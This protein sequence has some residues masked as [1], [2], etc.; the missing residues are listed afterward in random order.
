LDTDGL[1]NGV[2]D[3]IGAAAEWLTPDGSHQ[4]FYSYRQLTQGAPS[5]GQV[6]DRTP[7]GLE[8]L[9]LLP[10]DVPPS[11]ASEFGGC[12][13]DGYTTLFLNSGNLYAR[14]DDDRTIEIAPGA[15]GPVLPGGVNADGSRAFFVQGGN[16]FA[17]DIEAEEASPV[18]ATGDAT[19]VNVSPDG[20]HAYFVSN[21]EI[22]SGKGTAGSP[23]LYVWNGTAIEFI[24]TIDESD[25][26]NNERPGL[27]AWTRGFTAF[28][29][30]ENKERIYNTA[31]TTPDGSI[32]AFQSSA[33]LTSY[34][35]EGHIEIYRYDTGTR[36]LACVSCSQAPLAAAAENEFVFSGED[37]VQ[38]ARPELELDNL[39]SDGQRVVFETQG[40]LLPQ[41]VNGVR[42][43]YEWHDG[44]LSLISTGA[45]SAPSALLAVTPS[46]S[47]VF[48]LTGENLVPQGQ[49]TGRPA[50]YDA[51]VEGGLAS[52]QLIQ[53]SDCVGEACQGQPNGS[54]TLPAPGS[55]SFQGNGNLK[56]T[57]HRRHRHRGRHHGAGVSKRK[58]A[59][60]CGSTRRRVGR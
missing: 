54:P 48:F 40:S 51:R 30:A 11:G 31:R 27:G 13:Q 45:G 21:T 29:A 6:Y 41:D 44:Q 38:K 35:N 34:P 14:V 8:L 49:G 37:G 52:Q 36:E 18:S 32:F 15:G 19:L 55:S 59:H 25:M 28:P 12:S 17:Y 5:N 53:S 2:V 9:S 23:N 20:S 57:C 60:A 50:V 42:D 46:G 26:G 58:H 43:V 16:I 22:V 39:S 10:G 4:I 24:A 7:A 56:A 47:D 1:Q 3:D 33:Q